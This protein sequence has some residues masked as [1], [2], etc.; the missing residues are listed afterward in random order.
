MTYKVKLFLG[1]PVDSACELLL[2]GLDS[3]IFKIYLNNEEESALTEVIYRGTRY[4]GKYADEPA[5]IEDISLL[6][7]NIYSILKKLIPTYPCDTVPLLL[8]AVEHSDG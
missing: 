3:D 2:A 5:P 6:Q 1:F 7:G 4:L 8:F